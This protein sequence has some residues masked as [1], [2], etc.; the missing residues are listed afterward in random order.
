MAFR[1]VLAITLLLG[2]VLS[3]IIPPG[4][5]PDEADHMVRAYLLSQGHVFLKTERCQGEN[6]LCHNGSTMSGGPVDQGLLEYFRLH[7]PYRRHKES[8]LDLQAGR[9]IPWR[10][11]EVFFHAPGTGYYF[12]LVYLPQATA[13]ALGKTLGLTVENSYYLARAFAMTSG[14]LVLTLVVMCVEIGV[15]W[16]VNSMALL[17][18]GWHMSSHA[19]ALGLTVFAYRMAARYARDRRFAFGTWKMEILGGYT[20]ALLLVGVAV[21]MLVESVERMV[22]P[23]PIGYDQAIA[24][25][26]LGLAVNLVSAW[27]LKDDHH[28]HGHSHGHAHDHSHG[29]DHGHSHAHA[30]SASAGQAAHD[31]DH[32]ARHPADAHAHSSDHRHSDHDHDHDHDHAHATSHGHDEYAHGAHADL[33]LRAAYIHVLTDAATSILAI[34]ALFGGKWWGASWLDP[35][36]GIVGAVLVGVWAKGLLRDCALVLL[37]AEMD[38]PLTERITRTLTGAAMPVKVQD[39]HLW[40]VAND[41][42]ACIV[43]LQV[44]SPAV[45]PPPVADVAARDDGSQGSGSPTTEGGHHHH[46]IDAGWQPRPAPDY[47]RRLLST[48]P[49]LVHI[50]VEVNV[51]AT[52]GQPAVTH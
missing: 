17:A 21:T 15:G 20:S 3:A 32:H 19:F 10:G 51:V 39:L 26:V 16:A 18:D 1:W 5:S 23:L 28:H 13:L 42:Y 7:D 35:L 11:Q 24:T 34:L 30:N 45:T 14:V 6:A 44:A 38:N 41:K 9:V 48:H 4:K 2:G 40:R 29:H 22:N 36:M 47:F 50:T 43:A 12:P 37:D 46:D 25:A 33:N 8:M 52:G 27:M 49:E 31:H